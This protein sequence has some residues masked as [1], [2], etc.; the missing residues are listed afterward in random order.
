[1]LPFCDLLEPFQTE[2]LLLVLLLSRDH[3]IQI[4]LQNSHI[5]LLTKQFV[6]SANFS[7]CSGRPQPYFQDTNRPQSMFCFLGELL[8][9]N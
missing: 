7:D 5:P 2:F 1:M 9:W 3:P 8:Y 6:L 4:G